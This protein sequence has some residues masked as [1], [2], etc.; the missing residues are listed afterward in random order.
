MKQSKIKQRNA[1]NWQRVLANLP[2][3]GCEDLKK[4]LAEMTQKAK[5]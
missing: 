1:S 5:T 2:L 4:A 3:A